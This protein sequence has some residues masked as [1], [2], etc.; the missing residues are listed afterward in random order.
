MPKI[1]GWSTNLH[2]HAWARLL[3]D[4]GLVTE[5]ELAG[6]LRLHEETGRP[7]GE[8]LTDELALVSVAAI[9]D[10]LVLQKRWRPLGQMLVERGLITGDQLFEALH[11]HDR[12]GRP[13]R[14]VMRNLFQISSATLREVLED[15]RR[16]ELELDR[17]YTSGLRHAST[18]GRLA[19]RLRSTAPFPGRRLRSR[20]G[21]PR[22]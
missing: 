22:R 4:Q 3:L 9:R 21:S 10:L 12:S 11:E 6:A 16:L 2:V 13:L 7:L 17:E 20:S 5:D 19:G 8:I 15:Q 1:P 14:E 18:R